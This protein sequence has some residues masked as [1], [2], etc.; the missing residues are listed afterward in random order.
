MSTSPRLLAMLGLVLVSAATAA[1]LEL[2]AKIPLGNVHGRIDH[3]AIDV[4]RQRLFVAELG[5]DS[6]GV[7][8]L[9]ARKTVRTLTGLKQPQG[10]GY[11]PSTDTLYVANAG[12]GSVRLFR[13]EELA[14]IGQ[15]ELGDDADNVR[16]DDA[17]HRVYVGYGDGALAVIDTQSRR[18]IAD[19]VLK[20]HPESFQ[21]ER[22]GQ[23]IF[24]N[25]PDR[26]EIAS[27][28]RLTGKQ[29]ASW[30]TNELRANF[31]LALDE[32]HQALL[33]VFRSPAKVGAFRT[34]DGQLLSATDTCGDADDVFV[35]EKRSRVYVSCGE[36]FIDVIV[37]QAVSYATLERIP[38]LAGARTALYDSEIDRFIL[39]V[40]S[41]A[42]TASSIWLFRPGQ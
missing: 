24:I 22:W 32:P 7:V 10:V 39:A 42:G 11:A 19:I 30:R 13:G 40:R 18:K 17:A 8:D 29:V 27:V 28:D 16:V 9:R 36:G 4:N 34:A 37:Q 26:G 38:T 31:P 23:R 2:E 20:G 35:D 5:N 41:E 14:P 25:V 15:I 12:D 33:A 21:L 3:L 6:V 1:S